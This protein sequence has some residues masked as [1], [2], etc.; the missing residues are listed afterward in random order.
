MLQTL[1][2]SF[3]SP[4]SCD[5]CTLA[6]LEHHLPQLGLVSRGCSLTQVA[7][8]MLA[9]LLLVLTTTAL[10]LNKSIRRYLTPTT[11]TT[12][13]SKAATVGSVL[14]RRGQ[15]RHET[16]QARGRLC[17]QRAISNSFLHFSN[18]VVQAAL[19]FPALSLQREQATG[20]PLRLL[21]LMQNYEGGGTSG[22][23]ERRAVCKALNLT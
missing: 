1:V 15:K 12:T 22:S 11:T 21:L 10:L 9:L 6:E 19:L 5:A 14:G 16:S 8:L 20:L 7:V 13:I 17:A 18:T 4:K 2:L 3:Q 23:K